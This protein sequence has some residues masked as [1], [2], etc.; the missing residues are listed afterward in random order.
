VVGLEAD[1][2]WSEVAVHLPAGGQLVLYSDG[3]LDAQAPARQLVPAELGS[4]LGHADPEETA[5]ALMH[6]STRGERA[7]DDIALLV[8]SADAGGTAT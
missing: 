2:S 8:L 3:L 6:L 7:R 1:L 4:A 5:A